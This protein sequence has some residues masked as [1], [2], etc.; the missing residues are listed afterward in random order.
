MAGAPTPAIW[1]YEAATGSRDKRV[2][3]KGYEH[4]F[5]AENIPSASRLAL[6][7]D[8][9]SLYPGTSGNYAP[10]L[11]Y[12]DLN[13][14]HKA[15]GGGNWFARAVLQYR[16]PSD[17]EWLE[18]H[19]NKGILLGQSGATGRRVRIDNDGNV[20]EG[21]DSADADGKVK[22]SVSS[23][24]NLVFDRRV[25]YEVYSVISSDVCP[26]G[27]TGMD[28]YFY[29]FAAWVGHYN[30]APMTFFPLSPLASTTGQWL[31]IEV[32]ATPRSASKKM[33]TVRHRFMLNSDEDGWSAPCISQKWIQKVVEVIEGTEQA[34]GQTRYVPNWVPDS[35]EG[36]T[37]TTH[38]IGG[39]AGKFQVIGDLL[40][41]SR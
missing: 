5:V 6:I 20:I 25:I 30:V 8:A 2:G 1:A 32:S 15:A 35:G 37:R 10:A 29:E 28:V 16:T 7:P 34:P 14:K 3:S 11:A 22:W 9:W 18:A 33:Y 26:S 38:L 24:S 23:G 36:S 21:L 12:V 4:I 17:S 27:K 13:P 39:D 31:L 19:P 41:G 40:Y